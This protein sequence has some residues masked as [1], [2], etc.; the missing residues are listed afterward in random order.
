MSGILPIVVSNVL[1][2]AALVL[3]AVV[4][5]R[6]RRSPQLAHALWGLV[7]LKL[8]T[9]P[10][11]V[12][13]LPGQWVKGASETHVSGSR[14]TAVENRDPVIDES[15]SPTRVG[16]ESSPASARPRTTTARIVVS[17]PDD[18]RDLNPEASA[19]AD[20]SEP[21]SEPA[22]QARAVG[23][24]T[25]HW[26][27]IFGT[28]WCVG[29][30]VYSLVLLRRCVRF[31]RLI[32]DDDAATP[33]VIAAAARLAPMLGLKRCPPVRIVDAPIPPLVWSPGVKPII[34]LPAGLLRELDAAQCD[35]VI[36]HEL[37]HVRRRDHLV[38]WL[39]IVSLVV[40]WWN[41][42]AWF[43]R[44]KLR[45]AEEECCDAS[46]VCA[47]PEQRKSYGQAMFKTIE[48]LTDRPAPP[49]LAGSAFG[50]SNCK[51]RI[52]MILHHTFRRSA[53][54]P[55]R[56]LLLAL[57]VGV[58]PIAAT[59]MPQDEPN[60]R[61]GQTAAANPPEKS[62]K[63]AGV[64]CDSVNKVAPKPID[65]T[66][67]ALY[68][69]YISNTHKIS[70]TSVQ[71][72]IELVAARGHRDAAFRALLEN[73][74]V[75]SCKEDKFGN[76][77]RRL[78]D[79]VA[80]V[81]MH[82][83]GPRWQS[84]EEK[85]TGLPGQRV[86]QPDAVLYRKSPLLARVIEYGRK[87]PSSEIDAFV[88]A[89]RQ[90]H[91]PQGK[92]FLL[93][94]LHDPSDETPFA[95]ADPAKSKW[96]YRIR[97]TARFLAAVGLAELGV[98][99]GVR[100][101][102]RHARTNNAGVYGTV[103]NYPHARDRT[104]N[105]RVNC[106]YALRDLA[107]VQRSQDRDQWRDWDQWWR[108]NSASFTP[109]RVTLGVKSESQRNHS[110]DTGVK[111]PQGEWIVVGIEAEG[112]IAKPEEL[113]G[114]RWSIKGDVI[115]ATNPDGSGGRMRYTLNAEKS[116]KEI[117]L[118]ALDGNRKGQTDPGIYELKNGRLRVCVGDPHKRPQALSDAARK[119]SAYGTI[120]LEKKKP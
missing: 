64:G 80:K 89:V 48:Y 22:L 43:A 71:A 19:P 46:V 68:G 111:L 20:K 41:P 75:R 96:P 39:E 56:M 104:G 116:P 40:Y 105:L 112:R 63:T 5:T 4:V 60:V 94:V 32:A 14:V 114:M 66:T 87:S 74:F 95:G 21:A 18:P 102:V 99:E 78:L 1:F 28:V 77:R 91:H 62:E 55:A 118:T 88:F 73:D 67:K 97:G 98:K 30:L 81:L 13:S 49:V 44:R 65:A 23:L 52:E 90:A 33:D 34:L 29:A 57:L 11:A 61:S 119:D 85:R 36:A 50:S 42:I 54:W 86:L 37:A 12:I 72:A 109:R 6:F 45:E 16:N 103:R 107:G 2:A 120:T 108:K 93:D 17:P 51:R 27:E 79:L 58:L 117:D 38:R 8:I 59:A 26:L 100:W 92:Q 9:P 3:V 15:S 115:T 76:V 83:A 31:Q 106:E 24:V 10:L 25:M 35:C 7:L 53:S 47:L 113:R 84:E 82:D 101:L 69:Q 70:T 110:S